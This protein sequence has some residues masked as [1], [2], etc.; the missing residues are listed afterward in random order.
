MKQLICDSLNKTESVLAAAIHTP[1]RVPRKPQQ[2]G[3]GVWGV[4]SDSRVSAAVDCGETDGGDVREKIVVKNAV[5]ENWTAMEVRR[6][7]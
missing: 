2:L 7:C 1:D 3:A 4:W 6:Y 5:E